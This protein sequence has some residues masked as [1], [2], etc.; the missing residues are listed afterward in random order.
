[1][2]PRTQVV[3]L[4]FDGTLAATHLAVIECARRTSAQLGHGLIAEQELRETIAK[5]LPLPETFAAVIRGLSPAQV[6]ACVDVY[7]AHYGEVDAEHSI[8]FDEVRTTVQTMHATGLRLVVLSNKG[9]RAIATA[10]QRTVPS[11]LIG[12]RLKVH[13]YDDRLDC[14]LGSTRV[15][16]LP[17]GRPLSGS[18]LA[19]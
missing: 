15:L 11:R 17:R 10:L 4:D 1:M 7:R 14:F 9:S 13:L 2:R 18:S 16:A 19:R 5:G 12:H 8:L 3:L 6:A